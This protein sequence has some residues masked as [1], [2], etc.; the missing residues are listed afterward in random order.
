MAVRYLIDVRVGVK[1]A[2]AM[3]AW[4]LITTLVVV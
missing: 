1:W 2:K 4:V 3:A